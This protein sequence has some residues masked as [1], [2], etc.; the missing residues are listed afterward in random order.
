[1]ASSVGCSNM[2]LQWAES[3]SEAAIVVAVV[4]C[5]VC[6]CVRASKHLSTTIKIIRVIIY[7]IVVCLS[8]SIDIYRLHCLMSQYEP[9]V[10]MRDGDAHVD[11][12]VCY[13]WLWGLLSPSRKVTE[14][15][16]DGGK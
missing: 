7:P 3:S 10:L 14:S 9:H 16:V 1:M 2:G 8:I 5:I 6:V 12:N 15:Y 13:F 4:F 11:A